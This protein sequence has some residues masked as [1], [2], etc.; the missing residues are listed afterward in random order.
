MFIIIIVLINF[1]TSNKI[2]DSFNS[3][4]TKTFTSTSANGEKTTNLSLYATILFLF[5]VLLILY[6]VE[7]YYK[8]FINSEFYPFYIAIMVAVITF[9]IYS[10]TNQQ[11][12]LTMSQYVHLFAIELV[13][14][15]F[16][17]L[18][19]YAL[20]YNTVGSNIIIISSVS[21]FL[22]VIL[23]ILYFNPEIVEQITESYS[24]W[25]NSG[26]PTANLF[27]SI[28]NTIKKEIFTNSPLIWLI[29]II[30]LVVLYLFFNGN[31]VSHN[32]IKFLTHDGKHLMN[33]VEY[34]NKT[35]YLGKFQDLTNIDNTNTDT[36]NNDT[37]QDD[38]NYNYAISGWFY[39]NPQYNT[40]GYIP[41]FNYG[42]KPLIAYKGS[43]NTLKITV[44]NTYNNVNDKNEDIIIN[45]FKFQKWNNIVINCRSGQYIDV[46]INTKLVST[47]R[48]V[49]SDKTVANVEVGHPDLEGAACNIVYYN[50]NLP[51]WSIYTLY[52]IYSSMDP[53]YI[54]YSKSVEEKERNKNLNVKDFKS[55]NEKINEKNKQ[56]TEKYDKYE[57]DASGNIIYEPG[58]L[59]KNMPGTHKVNTLLWPVKFF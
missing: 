21:A 1:S 7:L 34:I 30:Q 44:K 43:D 33:D 3:S 49:I 17:F 48:V 28:P 50:R 55:E 36:E 56:L 15:I 22:A 58:E 45:D 29:L 5:V 38:V 57:R 26:S 8:Q 42:E 54:N 40:E 52:F 51:I 16:M 9:I 19:L 53:P 13:V 59:L 4:Y 32:I 35:I 20:Y 6:L 25:I 2:Y 37:T 41:V 47:Q 46:I 11:Y 27:L 24:N 31:D 10:F 23:I 14:V 18:I 39:L 12:D